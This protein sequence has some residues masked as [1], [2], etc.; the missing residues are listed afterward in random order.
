MR[1]NTKTLKL[2]S[3]K[4]ICPYITKSIDRLDLSGTCICVIDKTPENVNIKRYMYAY[5]YYKSSLPLSTFCRQL[6]FIMRVGKK[7]F[8]SLWLRL[9]GFF[10][11]KCSREVLVIS[12]SAFN[13]WIVFLTVFLNKLDAIVYFFFFIS[14]DVTIGHC[15]VEKSYSGKIISQRSSFW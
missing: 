6:A 15:D 1:F 8:I 2:S 13:A 14:Y 10:W 7:R 12:S 5:H 11:I 4:C 3:I 9:S